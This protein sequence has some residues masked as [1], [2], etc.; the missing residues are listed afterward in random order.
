MR[1]I[2][3]A[4]LWLVWMGVCTAMA[5]FSMGAAPPLLRV[6]AFLGG[7]IGCTLVG[8]RWLERANG[9]TRLPFR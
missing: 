7:T 8:A 1:R 6:G 4:F 5:I 2:G 9:E 3:G